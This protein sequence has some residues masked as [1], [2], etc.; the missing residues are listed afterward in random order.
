MN[1]DLG[2]NTVSVELQV[3]RLFANEKRRVSI[4][5]EGFKHGRLLGLYRWNEVAKEINLLYFSFLYFNDHALKGVLSDL[6]ESG[7]LR[8]VNLSEL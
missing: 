2:I 1:Q 6:E 4:T 7:D 3:G 8:Y 5:F